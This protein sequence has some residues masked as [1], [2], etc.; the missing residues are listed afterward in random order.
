[1]SA[2][3]T[4]PV[5]RHCVNRFYTAPTSR[6]KRFSCFALNLR[7]NNFLHFKDTETKPWLKIYEK[8]CVFT[9]INWAAKSKFYSKIRHVSAYSIKLSD[10]CYCLAWDAVTRPVSG[11]IR[12]QS[13]VAVECWVRKLR[14][15]SRLAR[16]PDLRQHSYR[17]A[18]SRDIT[19]HRHTGHCWP[20]ATSP[21]TKQ[22][23]KTIRVYN[24]QL[25]NDIYCILYYL[26]HHQTRGGIAWQLDGGRRTGAVSGQCRALPSSEVEFR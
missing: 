7:T 10:F 26:W 21:F 23:A 13:C 4:R 16:T 2:P 22:P 6:T 1:M 18:S 12:Q 11:P 8:L 9:I 24:I 3:N 5:L 17:A 19:T 20:D 25:S 14:C 15:V